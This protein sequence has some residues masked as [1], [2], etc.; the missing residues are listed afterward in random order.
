MG[1]LGRGNNGDRPQVPDPDE[2]RSRQAHGI[3]QRAN[4]EKMTQG[5]GPFTPE[6]LEKILEDDHNLTEDTLELMSGMLSRTWKL[7]NL[8]EANV[9]EFKWLKR[10]LKKKIFAAH[11]QQGSPVQGE[12]RKFIFDDPSDGLQPLNQRQKWEIDQLLMSLLATDT[13][14]EDMKQQ[15]MFGRTTQ[16]SEHREPDRNNDNGGIFSFR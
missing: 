15:E 6:Y 11:P 7:A 13:R 2:Q 10:A 12:Y 9:E 8:S 16:V 3:N 5:G 14:S 1:L 4:T